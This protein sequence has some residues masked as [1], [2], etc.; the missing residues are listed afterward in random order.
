MRK[1][2]RKL[3]DLYAQNPAATDKE[4][5]NALGRSRELV[6]KYRM[7]LRREGLLERDPETGQMIVYP[8]PP[9]EDDEDASEAP[10]MED[11]KQ[12][13]YQEMVDT[14]MRR[15]TDEMPTSQVVEI[16]R[17]V[18]KIMKEMK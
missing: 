11:P 1:S 4:L 15:V 18:R 8:A 12:V 10:P 9:E 16:F 5:A 13:T 3:Y 17:E 6:R 14:L 2:W 7:N